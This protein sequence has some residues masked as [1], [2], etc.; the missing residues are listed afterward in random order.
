MTFDVEVERVFSIDRA[1]MWNLWT[2]EEH[3]ARWMR[4]SI[5]EFQPTIATIDARP[6]GHYRFEMITKDGAVVAV[7]GVFV[8]LDPP[9]RLSF[10]W[11][12]EGSEEESFVEV[13]LIEVPDG[14]KVHVLHSKL[15]SQESAD[16]H[17]H[18]W[19]GCLDSIAVLY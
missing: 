17:Q 2:D 12:W 6:G 19:V 16:E 15:V 11:S 1:T 10:T 3:A 13:T 7:A 4:P 18:G 14:T 5:T 8:E 9:E